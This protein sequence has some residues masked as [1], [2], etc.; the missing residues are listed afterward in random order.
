MAKAKLQR[1][2]IRTRRVTAAWL[3]VPVDRCGNRG[4]LESLHTYCRKPD[5]E[6]SIFNTR[7]SLLDVELT[8][9]VSTCWF[10]RCN[11]G[12]RITSDRS[13]LALAHGDQ[14]WGIEA[15]RVAD[16]TSS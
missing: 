12:W 14:C 15:D 10:Q 11:K 9:W 4:A 1:R 8:P 6:Q 7:F 3:A 5:T 2:D 16:K 13:R